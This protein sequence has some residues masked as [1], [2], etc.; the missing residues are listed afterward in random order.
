M[1][2]TLI[3]AEAGVNHNGS[4]DTALALVD[5]AASAGADVVKFQTFNADEL[6]TPDAA[7]AAYQRTRAPA[8]SQHAMLRSLALDREAHER[9]A[10]RCAE[11]GIEFMSTAFDQG[12][13][14]WLLDLGIRRVKVG[15]GDLTNGPLLLTFARSGL[16][17]IVSTGMATLGDIESALAV[18]AF[19]VTVPSGQPTRADLAQ[20]YE[21]ALRSGS[22]KDRVTLLHCTSSYPAQP[23]DVHLTAM[24]TMGQAFGLPVGYSDHTVGIAVGLAAAARG[25]SILEKHFTLDRQAA[26]P[27]H[28][29]SLEPGGLR[30][31]VDGVHA[32]NA[33][34]GVP[35]KFPT[36]AERDTMIAA[37]RSIV[38][39][40]PIRRGEI[41]D[42]TNLH[43]LRPGSGRTPL[44]IWELLGRSASR[45]YATNELIDRAE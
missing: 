34:L 5:V 18:I 22:L 17:I 9:I 37:R 4:V 31:L 13:F 41:F 43:M 39:S 26:G 30:D 3:V 45:N 19:G 2:R 29:A 7:Q 15:S 33:A 6:V 20:A 44:D 25:A 12:S 35:T 11:R 27:D 10:Q 32:I 36:S 42:T 16:P 14:A 8:S 38:A 1:K 28:A 24:S 40:R 23:E 21:R